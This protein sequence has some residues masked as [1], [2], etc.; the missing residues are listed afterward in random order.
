MTGPIQGLIG[1]ILRLRKETFKSRKIN[2]FAPLVTQRHSF[3]TNRVVLRWNKLPE[4]VF[5]AP[6][7]VTFKSAL[8]VHHKRFNCYGD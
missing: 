2:N 5:S 1:N 7:L 6:S 8:D 4:S 3:F